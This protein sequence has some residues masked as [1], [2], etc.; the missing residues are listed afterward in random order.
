MLLAVW[1]KIAT[2]NS[3]LTSIFSRD[4]TCSAAN[5]LTVEAERIY[6]A[7]TS[8][9][10]RTIAIDILNVFWHDRAYYWSSS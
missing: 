5:L 7:G 3:Y 6:V 4:L 2:S 9:A 8:G 10:T 1:L